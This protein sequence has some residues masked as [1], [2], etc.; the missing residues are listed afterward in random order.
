MSEKG[1]K[2]ISIL[3]LV[4]YIFVMIIYTI[5]NAKDENDNIEKKIRDVEIFENVVAYVDSIIND[6]SAIEQFESNNFED[7][8]TDCVRSI[9]TLNY[10]K[11]CEGLC[12]AEAYV[13]ELSKTELTYRKAKRIYMRYVDNDNY[14]YYVRFSY[15]EDR[16]GS[17]FEHIGDKVF[18]DC[19]DE[20]IGISKNSEEHKDYLE[21]KGDYDSYWIKIENIKEKSNE[22]INNC[23][24]E[25]ISKTR[26]TPEELEVGNR[27]NLLI[28]SEAMKGIKKHSDYLD[29]E[30]N[31]KNEI[32]D[33]LRKLSNKT[34]KKEKKYGTKIK[35][36]IV[37]L[38]N[39]DHDELAPNELEYNGYSIATN[40]IDENG[41][42]GD[43]FENIH[44]ILENPKRN[45]YMLDF[46]QMVI[47]GVVWGLLSK[48]VPRLFGY[49]NSSFGEGMIYGAMPFLIAI[50]QIGVSHA[51]LEYAFLLGI[52]PMIK[53]IL[54][55][56]AGKKV[57][58]N[59]NI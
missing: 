51:Y 46:F 9:K 56:S 37:R 23:L 3:I 1:I 35:R 6:G 15:N 25:K 49:K 38:F 19:D 2:K 50:F 58:E 12:F 30:V 59:T 27:A 29:Y 11:K 16:L 32:Y 26:Y 54:L 41:E 34:A 7:F 43:G 39:E 21:I 13:E 48:V 36:A 33:C 55:G 45:T 42:F 44:I 4:A 57:N 40:F 20:I 47:L 22:K 52:V 53:G 17:I 5:A 28:T 14:N 18:S 24:Y 8:G 31:R 10:M